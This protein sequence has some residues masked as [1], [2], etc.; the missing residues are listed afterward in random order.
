MTTLEGKVFY[1]D[2]K[3]KVRI[4]VSLFTQSNY[5]YWSG[6]GLPQQFSESLN[7]FNASLAKDFKVWHIHIDNE[8]M[9]QTFNA[10]NVVSFPEFIVRSS[11]YYQSDL[12]NNALQTKTGIEVR[13]NPDYYAPAYQPATGQFLIQR[14]AEL[15]YF[16]VVD[17]FFV[18]KVKA[19]RGFL[20]IQNLS[21]GILGNGNFSAYHYPMPDRA[22]KVGFEWMFW[23]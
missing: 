3:W 19:V 13:Y 20:M 16:P 21:Q 15:P 1:F 8:F 6:A 7:G 11:L 14:N 10:G 23:N 12:F 22:F 5:I 9:Y 2:E 4:A 17:F 18:V